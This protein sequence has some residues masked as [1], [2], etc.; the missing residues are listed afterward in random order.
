VLK[1]AEEMNVPVIYGIKPG[2][3]EFAYP[4]PIGVKAKIDFASKELLIYSP[5]KNKK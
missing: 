3:G 1:I 4:M 5:F 2:H